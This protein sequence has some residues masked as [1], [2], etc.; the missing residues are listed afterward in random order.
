MHI[1]QTKKAFK[2][3]LKNKSA[4]TL[5]ILQFQHRPN[6]KTISMKHQKLVLNPYDTFSPPSS[7][8]IFFLF[9]S[10]PA[11]KTFSTFK[12]EMLISFTFCDNS[13]KKLQICGIN[14]H[15][16]KLHADRNKH[17]LIFTLMSMRCVLW[18]ISVHF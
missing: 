8:F 14:S 4:M 12:L 13:T 15:V 7:S 1:F 16:I 18:S 10:L 6:I 11:N 9:F 3:N 17:I 5:Y 2:N